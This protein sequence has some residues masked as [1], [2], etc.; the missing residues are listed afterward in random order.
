MKLR[1][2]ILLFSL[3]LFTGCS[4]STSGRKEGLASA[5]FDCDGECARQSL[6]TAEVTSILENSIRSANQLSVNATLAIVDRVGNVLALY[7]MT[8]AQTNTTIN[9]QISASGGL[10]GQSVPSSLVAISKAGTGAFLSSQGQAFSSRTA[11]QIIQENFNPGENSAP[12]GP[13][14]GVQF[15]QLPCSDINVRLD[16]FT[17]GRPGGAKPSFG[18]LI[19]PRS[20]P[21]G[22]SADPGG[23]PLYEKGD[24]VGGLGIEIDGVY[25]LDRDILNIDDDIEERVALMGSL[26][27]EAPSKRV[28]STINVGKTLRYS[29]LTYADLASITN[30]ETHNP[31]LLLSLA[32]Y[33][34][35]TIKAGAE[36]GSAAS[37]VLLSSRADGD[38][39]ILVNNLGTN[40]FASQ[41][42][43]ALQGAELQSAEV[44]AL[45]DSAIRVARRAR[46]AI[47]RPL[48][49][50]AQVNIW[51]VDHL[52]VPLGFTRTADAPVFGIDVALQKARSAALFSSPDAGSFLSAQGFGDQVTR[53]Q[54]LVGGD[55]LATNFAMS[56]RAI[57]NLARPFLP[58][59]IS[60]DEFGPLSLPFPST[61]SA[62]A[63]S[64]S[65]FNTGLQS[66]L[67]L[68]KV[69]E[70]L[71][72]LPAANYPQN[73][74]A[75]RMGNGIQIFPGGVPLYRGETMIGAMG[76]SGD[77]ID[78]DD[79]IAFY[80]ASRVGLDEAN[81][82]NLGDSEFGFLPARTLRSDQNR[83]SNKRLRM[84]FI[85]C[86]E[87]PLR[88]EAIQNVCAN[89]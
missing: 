78:Q 76:V 24:L 18:G 42:G 88:G 55:I 5:D 37:G 65:P 84:R 32:E 49:T 23:I 50:A 53:T 60:S 6:S 28:A 52:G 81:H 19:G 9:G 43:T 57:G 3:S 80:G 77:G 69:F 11:S 64:W 62:G 16:S 29:D 20:L 10:E 66:E 17:D 75:S 7:Q 85:S 1:K 48:G 83:F 72:V 61:T 71:Q 86:P 47:R 44:E 4:G 25:R 45:L 30:S 36:F 40:R 26:G 51:V 58:D 73:C 46:S 39:N 63:E 68:T 41:S 2:S 12:A 82:P 59:G 38:A 79:L 33:F 56:S 15:S 21:L 22:L 35:G 14:F 70:A 13:L 87:S 89:L 54:G 34:D 27:F 74:R 8:G 31:A 67:V